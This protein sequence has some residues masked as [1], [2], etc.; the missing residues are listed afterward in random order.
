MRIPGDVSSG[1]F[2]IVAGLI[3]L[4]SEIK[5]AGL[6][7][8]PTRTGILDALLKMG[9]DITISNQRALNDEPIADLVVRSSKLEGVEISGSDVV[10]MIDEFPIFAVAASCADGITRVID[11]EELRFK[12]SDRISAI[13][14]ELSKIGVQIDEKPDGF[15]ID[16]GQSIKG[17]DVVS[18]GDHRLAMSL[19]V[20]GLASRDGVRVSRAGVIGESFP[21]FVNILRSLGADVKIIS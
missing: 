19:A 15:V 6:G 1:A 7:I 5:I 11:A 9:A 20:A 10:R 16:G 4:D 8:N 2:I 18:H 17:G 14:S 12:E 3:C 21:D 13:C